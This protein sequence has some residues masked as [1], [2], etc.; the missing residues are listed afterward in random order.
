MKFLRYTDLVARGIIRSRMTLKRRIDDQDFP[1]GCLLSPNCRAWD[2]A[3]IEAWLLTRPVARKT[4]RQEST[5]PDEQP[6]NNPTLP[7][8][9]RPPPETQPL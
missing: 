7:A 9:A 4:A 2:E 6:G 5:P 8:R 1:P 3:E